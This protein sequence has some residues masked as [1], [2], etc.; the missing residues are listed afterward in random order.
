MK[1]VCFLT[2]I[3]SSLLFF[4]GSCKKNSVSE[5]VTVNG[6]T[7]GCRVNGVPFIA[8]KWDY[9]NNIPPV[10]INFWYSIFPEN[11]PELQ[12]IAE[13]QNQ[14]IEVWLKKPIAPGRYLLNSNTLSHPTIAHPP[15]YG[16][17]FK[18][19]PNQEFITSA[20]VGGYVDVIFIDTVRQKIEGRFEFTGT[21]KTTGTT[22]TVTNG[23]FK[24]F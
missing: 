3:L 1:R 20:S 11:S 24:N 8:D 22:V 18:N 19:N 17:Y 2:L 10:R 23:Y 6:Q 16:L 14:Y 9:G 5:L 12:V 21:E 13:K 15:H 7:F 4:G